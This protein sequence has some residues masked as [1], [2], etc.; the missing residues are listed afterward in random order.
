M[1]PKE[2]GA[3]RERWECK[4]PEEGRFV[5]TNEKYGLVSTPFWEPLEGGGCIVVRVG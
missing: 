5:T 4:A 2:T 1:R 3:L